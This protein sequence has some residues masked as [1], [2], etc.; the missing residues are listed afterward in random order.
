MS[1]KATKSDSVCPLSYP[2]FLLHVLC[3]FHLEPVRLHSLVNV[4]CLTSYASA[5]SADISDSLKILVSEITYNAF[6]GALN[7]SPPLVSGPKM[8]GTF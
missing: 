2:T 8:D 4:L 3:V 6:M 1:Q 7:P 5:A